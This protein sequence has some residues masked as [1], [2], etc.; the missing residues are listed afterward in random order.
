MDGGRAT[1]G[2]W[3][4][5]AIRLLGRG[6]QRR[7]DMGAEEGRICGSGGQPELGGGEGNWGDE[8]GTT[9]EEVRTLNW[10]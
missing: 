4:S 6:N 9:A 7:K 3:G 5:C 8:I 1:I 2:R 10:A